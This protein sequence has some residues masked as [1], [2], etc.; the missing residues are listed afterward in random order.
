MTVD[1]KVSKRFL[2]QIFPGLEACQ[3]QR[4]Y[5]T[6]ALVP[7]LVAGPGGRINTM[8]FGASH[9][10]NIILLLITILFFQAC[11]PTSYKFTANKFNN[12]FI[13]MYI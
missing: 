4:A 6:S 13:C 11:I 1:S 2:G 10:M 3:D 7:H 8:I 9:I 12:Y 5:L